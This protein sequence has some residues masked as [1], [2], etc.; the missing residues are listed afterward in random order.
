M[1]AIL[2]WLAPVVLVW[3][4][5]LVPI[6]VDYP[7]SRSLSFA[8][9]LSSLG[10]PSWAAACLWTV[11]LFTLGNLVWFAVRSGW[12]APAVMDGQYVIDARGHVLR[13]LTQAEYFTRREAELS[14]ITGFMISLYFLPMMYRWYRRT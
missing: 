7:T 6:I 3:M 4:V 11:Q 10:M 13:V 9:K 1:D 12:G 8:A 2:P 5:L 14:M